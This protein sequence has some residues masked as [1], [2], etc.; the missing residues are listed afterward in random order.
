MHAPSL[1]GLYQ[2]PVPLQSGQIVVANDDYL[3]DSILQP[4]KNVP[5]GYQPIRP[6]FQCILSEEQII[7]LIA[8]IKSQR[9]TE[10][11]NPG[12]I[13]D[14]NPEP[15]FIPGQNYLNQE[16]TLA[17]WL[18]THD[19][20]RIAL[21]YLISITFFFLIGSLAAVLMRTELMFPHGEFF[22]LHDL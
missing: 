21:L 6:S 20:K 10:P 1:D 16:K 15:R 17:S 8:Y 14:S 3:R 18:F 2:Q 12:S 4:S 11:P 5:A 13:H 7:A 9:A 22:T 19:H